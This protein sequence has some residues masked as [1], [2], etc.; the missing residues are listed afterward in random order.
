M[1]VRGRLE[2]EL[3]LLNKKRT[4]VGHTAA[5]YRCGLHNSPDTSVS[6]RVSPKIICLLSAFLS[7][8]DE[9]ICEDLKSNAMFWS[10]LHPYDMTYDNMT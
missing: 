6:S 2:Q 5:H 7:K 10:I 4:N 9:N 3:Q 1:A 8:I